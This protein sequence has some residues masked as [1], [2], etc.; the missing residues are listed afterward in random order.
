MILHCE[1]SNKDTI[2]ISTSGYQDNNSLNV[3]IEIKE[4]ATSCHVVLDLTKTIALKN[5]L[6]KILQ[7]EVLKTK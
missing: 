4:R 5:E 7:L 3:I 1:A 2:E 6:T